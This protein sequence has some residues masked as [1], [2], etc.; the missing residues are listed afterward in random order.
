MAAV[1]RYVIAKES[2]Y[3]LDTFQTTLMKAP[4]AVADVAG[5]DCQG[6]GGGLGCHPDVCVLEWARTQQRGGNYS[7]LSVWLS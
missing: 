2:S 5:S 3:A 4:F 1:V 7:L 6:E